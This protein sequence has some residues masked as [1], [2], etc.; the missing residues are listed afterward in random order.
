MF[1][2][3]VVEKLNS[4]FGDLVPQETQLNFVNGVANELR[5]DPEVMLQVK[6]NT[7]DA[8]K[9]GRLAAIL[10]QKVLGLLG[11][12]Q[13]LVTYLIQNRDTKDPL[14]DLVYDL[15]THEEITVAQLKEATK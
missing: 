15:L 13:K 4:L 5:N 12:Y 1:L 7:P 10:P 6:H 14:V 8:A 9:I 3:E 11:D 2:H